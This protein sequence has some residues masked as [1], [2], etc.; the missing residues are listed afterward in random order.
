MQKNNEISK[1]GRQKIAF[2]F[3][4][5]TNK[6]INIIQQNNIQSW[7][8]IQAEVSQSLNLNV[9]VD[10]IIRRAKENQIQGYLPLKKPLLN[11]EKANKRLDFAINIKKQLDSKN[12][13]LKNFIFTDE[14]KLRLFQSEVSGNVYIKCKKEE[15]LEPKNVIGSVKYG[16]GGICFWGSISY[17]GVG[18]LHMIQENITGEIYSKQILEKALVNSLQ[19][20]NINVKDAI[21][22]EDLDPKHSMRCKTSENTAK[23]MNFNIVQDYPP[24]SPDVNPIENIWSLLKGQITK[25]APSSL[26]ELEKISQKKW[27]RFNK[28]RYSVLKNLILSFPR[29]I[30]EVIQSKGWYT[31]Y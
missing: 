27:M 14:T 12:L 22:F 30:E 15:R 3:Q 11:Q 21:I 4:V 25:Q 28:D 9:S 31:K 6:I 17:V 18:E 13:N 26:Q 29:R 10:T 8:N 23:K 5:K 1:G 24:A 20:M 7:Q 19:K 2:S 16:G